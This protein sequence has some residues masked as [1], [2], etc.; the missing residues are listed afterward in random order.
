MTWDEYYDAYRNA[1]DN[2]E[3]ARA[4]EI[5]EEARKLVSDR[6]QRAWLHQAL[7]DTERRWFVASVFATQPVPKALREP[8]L[9]A[10]LT[11]PVDAS[12]VQS[13][14]IPLAET[15]G[16]EDIL[17]RLKAAKQADPQMAIPVDKASYWVG[18][19]KKSR[20]PV[21]GK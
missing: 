10:A 15:F 13:F 11:A 19:I 3:R 9:R 17:G 4:Y 2:R 20:K 18:W 14:I 12:A 21:T 5:L 8:M 16:P 6:A 7:E 1:F